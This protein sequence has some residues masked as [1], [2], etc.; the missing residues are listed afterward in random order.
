MYKLPRPP[1]VLPYLQLRNQEDGVITQYQLNGGDITSRSW[2]SN[3]V[4]RDG[5]I[6]QYQLNGG[7]ITSTSWCSGHSR[8]AEA[9]PAP[10]RYRQSLKTN[11][12]RY[13][14]LVNT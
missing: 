5:V 6:T 2:C 13:P 9:A 14:Q 10:E 7:D 4:I 1:P 8:A 11:G 12:P 3:S